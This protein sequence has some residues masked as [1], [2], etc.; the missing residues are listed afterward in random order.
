M[1]NL[2][3]VLVISFGLFSC[4]K[5]KGAPE[6][7]PETNTRNP[8]LMNIML[9]KNVFNS[10]KVNVSLKPL[11]MVTFSEPIKSTSLQAIRLSAANGQNVA[12]QVSLSKGDSVISIQPADDLAYLSGYDLTINNT[13][14]S[15]SGGTLQ[16]PITGSFYTQM[17][18]SRK[19]PTITYDQL[20]DKIQQQTI[21]YFWDYAHPVSGLAREGTGHDKEIVTIGGSSFGIMALIVAAERGYKTR[22]EVLDRLQKMVTFLKDKAQIYHGAYP[23]WINGSTGLTIPFSQND[24]GADLVET[25]F[26]IQGLLCARQYFN[27]SSSAETNL[28]SDINTIA[29]RVEWSWFRQGDQNVLYWHWSPDK[30]WA[31]N[32]P[33]RGWN[34]SLVTYVLA[35]SSKN[36][37]IPKI[38]YDQG[39]A[40][41]GGMKNGNKYYGYTLPL[42]PALGGPLFFEHYSFLGLDP[43]GL[44]D[45]YADYEEQTTNHTLIN[46]A[47]CKANP[48]QYFGYSDSVWGLSAS[49][50][51]NGYSAS[52]PTNDLGFIA[53]TAAVSSIPFTSDESKAATS[54]FYYVLGDQL[55]GD[56][57]FKD[58]FSLDVVKNKGAWYADSY[59]AIDQGPQ[60]VMI[61]N[62]RSGLLWNLFMSCPE[63]KSG[64]SKLGFQSPHL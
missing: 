5:E 61:E 30:G 62:Y 4:G 11:I 47:Y 43:K 40:K 36:Y 15:A 28:R 39:W 56:Y 23:H 57:G 31:M 49:N 6:P 12:I 18:S 13:L 48:N 42:G 35:A 26:L 60:I 37:S 9:D 59:L 51:K 19:F 17:D 45:A 32:L 63:V 52:S 64:L 22:T 25:S 29:D 54:F 44:K 38:V 33:I 58:A 46:Y 8:D 34:E 3:L 55:F 41:D 10:V 27:G 16:T 50:I 20:L 53:P 1:K 21:R 24:N 14:Q 2:F 7:P